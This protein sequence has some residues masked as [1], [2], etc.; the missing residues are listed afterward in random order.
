MSCHEPHAQTYWDVDRRPLADPFADGQC[1]SCHPS[2]L[3]DVEAHTF[4][5]A[6]SDGSKCV[7]CHMPYLQHPEVGD[8]IPFAR[9]DHT[10][11]IPRPV[12]DGDL[13]IEGACIQCHR[14]R[15]PLELQAEVREQWGEVRPH[16]PLVSG[17]GNEFRAR[18]LEDAAELLLHPDEVD[19]FTQF[20]AL[21]R[22]LGG[23]LRPDTPLPPSV[24][25]ALGRLV[26]HPDLDV[27][28]L[29]LA[30]LH[31]T[32]GDDDDVRRVLV[33][34]L[35]AAPDDEALRG[36]W[37]LALGFLGD[38]ARDEGDF[39]TGRAA[40]RKALELRPGDPRVLHSL[41]QLHSRAG[42]YELAA[43]AI[44][45]SLGADPEQPLAWV[46]LGIA[47][48]GLGDPAGAR[49]AYA[50][51]IRL[52]PREALAHFNLGNAHQ[53]S[54]RLEEAAEAYARAVGADPGLGLG[55]FELARTYIRLER[56]EE[57]LPHARRAVEFLPGHAPSRQ[58]L[59]D[60]EQALGR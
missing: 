1:T 48:A 11:A 21:S 41:G 43:D 44:R 59:S 31:W 13:G 4:H 22:L 14:D 3:A 55:H 26:E 50:E 56:F 5:P 39:E 19:P 57:A 23:Y 37:L 25:T 52:N 42:A 27:R 38:R 46:N 9:S 54:D 17:I 47:L 34:A 58:M 51:A 29:A 7:S 18:T 32:S 45:E 12:F 10:V 20:Q 40:Y 28:G 33:A 36:R 53:R 24:G 60:L 49:D 30:S 15:S 16:R 8:G 6:G 35:E 2:K